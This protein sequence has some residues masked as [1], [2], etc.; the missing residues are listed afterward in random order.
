MRWCQSS[1]EPKLQSWNMQ[2][3][4]MLTMM[5][6]LQAWSDIKH[7][8]SP[9]PTGSSAKAWI[10]SSSS[11]GSRYAPA[12]HSH[13][14]KAFLLQQFNIH[15]GLARLQ[16]LCSP[17][18]SPPLS[19]SYAGFLS[20][21]TQLETSTQ[22]AEQNQDPTPASFTKLLHHHHHHPSH[23]LWLPPSVRD[24]Q[25]PTQILLADLKYL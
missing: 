20:T 6:P 18:T 5:L 25:I 16:Q 21:N 12:F 15:T 17:P 1:R 9:R 11:P 3:S 4:R 10:E 13:K 2:T 24:Q 22:E 8:F 7:L 14:L 23:D 19:W